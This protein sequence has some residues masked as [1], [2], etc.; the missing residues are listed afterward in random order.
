MF[1]TFEF[2]GGLQLLRHSKKIAK[3]IAKLKSR[4]KKR[5]IPVIYVN[6]NFGQWRSDW[7]AVFE[8]CAG[9][10]CRGHMIAE[11]LKP[12]PDDYFVLKPKHSAFYCT[13][14]EILL[15][16]MGAK[17]LIVV[18]IAADI[19][20][21]FSAQDAHVRDY[22]LIVPN[23][24]VASETNGQKDSALRLMKKIFKVETGLSS[25]LRI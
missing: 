25:S 10:D 13:T 15:R 16:Q 20:V 4:L 9:E 14:L 8:R 1:N 12:E 5:S 6:D 11:Q 18:G 21:L 19:C 2:D 7:R 17:K 24:C 23:D 3:Q 22:D